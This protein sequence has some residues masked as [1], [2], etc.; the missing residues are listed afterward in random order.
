MFQLSGTDQLSF[1]VKQCI[2]KRN[3]VSGLTNFCLKSGN[4]SVGP[5]LIMDYTDY[6]ENS[7][8]VTWE[9]SKNCKLATKYKCEQCIWIWL[10]MQL[11]EDTNGIWK[12]DFCFALDE[13]INIW[14]CCKGYENLFPENDLV[15]LYYDSELFSFA[16]S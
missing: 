10:S 6:F 1:I 3:L 14:K 7:F 5:F 9:A 2:Q 13:M 16:T 12:Q 4:D 11:L 15:F 8:W